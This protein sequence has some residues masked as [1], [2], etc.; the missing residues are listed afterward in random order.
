[1]KRIQSII[2]G[3][4]FC[5]S[6]CGG[7]KVEDYSGKTPAMDI[8]QFFNGE[9]VAV[10][11]FIDR[12]GMADP[13]MSVT[14]KGTFDKDGGQMYEEFIYSDGRNDKRTWTIRFVDDHHFIGTAHDI[15]GEAKG[16]QYGNAVHMEYVLRVLH[17]GSSY[18]MSM[19]DWMYKMDDKT[20][21]NR[22]TMSK[23]GF[24]VGELILTFSKL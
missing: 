23:F 7:P 14:M 21:I 2:A 4:L 22:I 12:S 15:I 11:V 6:G 17:K 20:I 18:D 10:G 8:R 24:K 3:L 9:V 13:S 19:D 1:M 5:L 16:T